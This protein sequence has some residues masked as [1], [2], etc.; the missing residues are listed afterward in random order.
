MKKVY[1]KNNKKRILN[2]LESNVDFQ[3]SVVQIHKALSDKGAS[4]NLT[5][6]YRQLEKLLNS[7]EVLQFSSEDG[8]TKLFQINEENCSKHLHVRCGICGKI[9]H[10]DCHKLDEFLE[11]IDTEHHIKINCKN[12]ILFGICESCENSKKSKRL[13]QKKAKNIRDVIK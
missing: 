7:G 4:L 8:K 12:S 6:V 11:H 2:F 1:S 9:S 13:S 10:I 5:T 3:F